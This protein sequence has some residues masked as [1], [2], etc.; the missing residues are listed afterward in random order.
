MSK[1]DEIIVGSIIRN[2][3]HIE[4]AKYKMYHVDDIYY[5]IPRFTFRLKGDSSD[6]DYTKI[7]ECI[8]SFSGRTKWILYKCSMSK[9]GNYSLAPICVYDIDREY[10]SRGIL[11]NEKDFFSEEEYKKIC[12]HAIYDIPNLAEHLIKTFKENINQ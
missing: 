4:Q 10:Y 11:V 8:D 6:L 7:R 2:L 9:K 1:Y 5:S 3:F 12:E